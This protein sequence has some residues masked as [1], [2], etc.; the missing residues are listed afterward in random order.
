MKHL[1][2]YTIIGIV[3]VLIT[4]TLAH[5]L[6]NWSGN[7]YIVGFFT[8][9]NE[10]VWEHMKLLFFPMLI[11]SLIIIL[12]F[13]KTYSCVTSSLFFG[14]LVGTLLVPIFFYT[15]TSIIGKDIFILDIGTFILSIIL[16]FWLS[17]K[18]TSSRRLEPYTLLL[19][20]LVFILF[21]GFM[22]FT[23]NPPKTRIFEDPTISKNA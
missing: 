15:Y 23:Y 10:S 11:Y 17:Y 14:I 3:F 19:C 6:Y 7:N 12:N 9:I 8:P 13:K 5:F 22:L 1:K 2:R 18:L 20:S 16:A 21:I 4:G